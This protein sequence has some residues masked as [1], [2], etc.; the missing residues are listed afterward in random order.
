VDIPFIIRQRLDQLGLEQRNLAVAAQVTE[1]Y[2]SQLLT[3]RKAPPAPERT[4]IYARIETFLKLPSGEIA[5]LAESGHREEL[6]R[7]LG[8]PPC[9]PVQE[10]SRGGTAQADAELAKA[11]QHGF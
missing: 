3:S 8:A 2:I 7:K 9:P 10:R 1:S 5:K 4:D 11:D 6:K